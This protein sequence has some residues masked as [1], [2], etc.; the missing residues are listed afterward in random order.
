MRWWTALIL[1][2]LLASACTPQATP[3][4]TSPPANETTTTVAA[5][6]GDPCRSGDLAFGTDGLIAA[7]GEE[8]PDVTKLSQIRWE[9]SASCERLVVG[10]T[11]DTGAPAARLGLT[12]VTILG[13]AGIVRIDLP[14]EI[15]ESAVADM[16]TDAELVDR[17][18]VTRDEEG[19]LRI[20]VHMAP[21]IA[22]EAR[23]FTASSPASLIIDVAP[24]PDL[25]PPV[26]AATSASAVIVT[27]QSGPSLY[28]F[29]VEAYAPPAQFSTHVLVTSNEVIASSVS[30]AL[31]GY[32]DTWQ[33]F[34]LRV[35][36][37]PSG[38][39]TVFVGEINS[40]G[41]PANGATVLLDLP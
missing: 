37:G 34:S 29:T 3:T 40:S 19:N 22:I 16:W 20:D 36:D 10:F 11:T 21:G 31:K 12:G 8:N 38:P 15:T 2:A 5:P 7:L 39:T 4:T 6:E 26:P 27:P 33:S 32:T 13:Y 23:A 24:R 1:L 35:D 25:T 41:G 28:P 17:T 9:G 30:V 18:F 14:S